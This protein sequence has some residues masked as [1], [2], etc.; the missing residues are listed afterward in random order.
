MSLKKIPN[1]RFSIGSFAVFLMITLNIGCENANT[2][3]EDLVTEQFDLAGE[4]ENTAAQDILNKVAAVVPDWSST[5][6]SVPK[7]ISVNPFFKEDEMQ[8]LT[9]LVS[10][11]TL[12]FQKNTVTGKSI[13]S[14]ADKTEAIMVREE[15]GF[16]KYVTPPPEKVMDPADFSDGE[17]LTAT[18]Q[19]FDAFSL[20]AFE[21]STDYVATGVAETMKLPGKGVASPKVVARHV[22]LFR[23]INGIRVWDSRFMATY[24]MDGRLFR[25]E[26]NWPPFKLSEKIDNLISRDKAVAD[27]G[28]TAVKQYGKLENIE[29]LTSELV[30][31]YDEENL[32]YEPVV[33][34]FVRPTYEA[35]G[36]AVFEYSLVNGFA[37]DDR[38]ARKANDV[39]D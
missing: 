32:V 39:D 7:D 3:S 34:L 10:K 38:L 14:S 21:K 8:R 36:P 12:I 6:A 31:K 33:F 25:I 5:I 35:D 27:L 30:Y 1:N 9:S 2:I 28:V 23:R 15:T 18:N 20:P 29:E 24:S 37:R 16:W 19:L 11:S 26:A 17:A 22:R 4:V 13:Y